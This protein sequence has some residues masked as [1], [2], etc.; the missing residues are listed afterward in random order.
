[1]K[2]LIEESVLRQALETFTHCY[3][4]TDR[5]INERAKLLVELSTALDTAEKVEPMAWLYKDTYGKL[6]VSQIEE[7]DEHDFP[8]FT[9]PAP[10]TLVD[11]LAE[12]IAIATREIEGWKAVADAG[13]KIIAARD[14]QIAE[15]EEK[16]KQ[17]IRFRGDALRERDEWKT[18]AI[19][20][21][22]ARH[23][24]I[25]Q[26]AACKKERD[27]LVAVLLEISQVACSLS[28]EQKIANE[29]LAKVGADKTGE[30]H[31]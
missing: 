25:E 17:Q 4:E 26:L 10:T 13:E 2:I 20:R 19:K 31:E 5:R 27:E 18:G 14:E 22:N 11:S 15:L 21:D 9:H 12:K 28:P 6:K 30:Q 23:D 24:A 7:H 29:A 8:V 3:A 1:M 16:I